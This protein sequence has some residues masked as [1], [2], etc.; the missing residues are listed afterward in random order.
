M[1]D[2]LVYPAECTGVMT[3]F[4]TVYINNDPFPADPVTFEFAPSGTLV[5]ISHTFPG[6][7][8]TSLTPGQTLIFVIFVF[9][10]LLILDGKCY[11]C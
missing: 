10:V 11:G 1:I 4:Q 6:V 8:V 9:S 5:F 7:T 2:V 3:A